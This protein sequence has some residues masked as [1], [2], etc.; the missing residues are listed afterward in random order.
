MYV[1]LLTQMREEDMRTEWPLRLQ[2]VPAARTNH[3]GRDTS[4]ILYFIPDNV[5]HNEGGC[6]I[7]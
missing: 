3:T 7:A 4:T 1:H 5:I 6:S 2:L